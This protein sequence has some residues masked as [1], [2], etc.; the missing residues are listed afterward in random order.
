MGF[1]RGG[2]LVVVCVL[3]FLIL[4][5]GS[6]FLIFSHSLEY[7]NVQEQL[8][9]VVKNLSENKSDFIEEDFDLMAEMERA[10]NFMLEHCQNEALGDLLSNASYVFSAGGYTFTLSCNMLEN[11]E[12]NFEALIDE[13]IN[14]IIYTIYYD[15]YDCKFWD[16]LKKTKYPFF[17]ISEK[18]K[19]YWQEKFYQSL[20]AFLV[21][22]V[23]IFL[24]VEQKPNLFIVIGSIMVASSFILLKFENFLVSS[25]KY[26]YVLFVGLFFSGAPSV[27]W[28]ILALGLIILIIGIALRLLGVNFTK[29]KFSKKEVEGIVKKELNKSKEEKKTEEKSSKNQ[30]SK[31]KKK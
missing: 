2:L 17:L 22:V 28:K 12:E 3:F 27:F 21:L 16:C 15:D 4:L 11:F 10:R 7:E 26:P 5:L 31:K 1:V 23:L 29:K 18:A 14:N 19:N 20:I 9:P 25:I 24:L 30:P 13:G 6:L 8:F